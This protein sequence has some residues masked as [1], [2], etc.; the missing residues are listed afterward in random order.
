MSSH[1]SGSD[2]LDCYIANEK[3]V[4]PWTKDADIPPGVWYRA[5]GITED[6]RVLIGAG[7]FGDSVFALRSFRH[8][9]IVKP[10]PV[11]PTIFVER[12][13]LAEGQ[14]CKCDVVLAKGDDGLFE[15]LRERDVNQSLSCGI[16]GLDAISIWNWGDVR[17]TPF[18]DAL[19]KKHSI[20][21]V[22]TGM[23]ANAPEMTYCPILDVPSGT[24]YRVIGITEGIKLHIGNGLHA[25]E[26]TA[27]RL[28]ESLTEF[29]ATLVERIMVM[30]EG[31]EKQV[32]RAILHAFGDYKAVLKA[33]CT[34]AAGRWVENEGELSFNSHPLWKWASE[35]METNLY[36]PSVESDGVPSPSLH[37]LSIIEDRLAIPPPTTWDVLSVFP[38]LDFSEGLSTT[39]E[40]QAIL[41]A[42]RCIGCDEKIA[43]L[44]R[45][46]EFR[47]NPDKTERRT[48]PILTKITIVKAYGDPLTVSSFKHKRTRDERSLC[49]EAEPLETQPWRWH[50]NVKEVFPFKTEEIRVGGRK[51]GPRY[52]PQQPVRIEDFAELNLTD[53][54]LL[55]RAAANDPTLD[56]CD[57]QEYLAALPDGSDRKAAFMNEFTAIA[58]LRAKDLLD[59]E[60]D[61]PKPTKTPKEK[62]AAPTKTGKKE[63]P[64]KGYTL[65][66]T[67]EK[68]G[69]VL[70]KADDPA[71]RS[72]VKSMFGR[73]FFRTDPDGK[74]MEKVKDILVGTTLDAVEYASKGRTTRVIVWENE[75][76]E[77]SRTEAE[78]FEDDRAAMYQML[79]DRPE[80]LDEVP[81][82]PSPAPEEIP[83]V[84]P[85]P[86]PAPVPVQNEL[87]K[88]LEEEPPTVQAN[89]GRAAKKMLGIGSDEHPDS[90]LDSEHFALVQ[91]LET[92][93]FHSLARIVRL[94]DLGKKRMLA[95]INDTFT[96]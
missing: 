31:T 3:N 72:E 77:D 51:G 9:R 95:A 57:F 92:D 71:N 6:M 19:A 93:G 32:S 54:S 21:D 35:P 12:I 20:P 28:A 67:G 58:F 62:K 39:V 79:A 44:V 34:D 2:L 76:V 11:C 66:T 60:N 53:R 89:E 13:D 27:T 4:H 83:E 33:Q 41:L 50:W 1:N 42:S 73:M 8:D 86:S 63:V 85:E 82:P 52:K 65:I 80:I 69:Q 16:K 61:A 24:W 87:T 75:E 56:P 38:N 84:M 48:R 96:P 46:T 70:I 90:E 45:K 43:K 10:G 68:G 37:D 22:H 81:D 5:I 55:D 14:R 47:E 59:A 40:E 7:L 94:M 18:D 64:K 30:G 15:S 78:K 91:S 17:C 23:I 26:G 74:W 49:T 29:P 25:D 36:V 88:K